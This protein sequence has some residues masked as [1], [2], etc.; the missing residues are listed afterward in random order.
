MS[1]S[2]A[3]ISDT[4]NDH[5]VETALAVTAVLL[6]GTIFYF[7]SKEKRVAAMHAANAARQ[8]RPSWFSRYL[9]YRLTRAQLKYTNR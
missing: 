4:I 8:L 3:S 9:E 2:L 6:I 7:R 5:Q 1:D